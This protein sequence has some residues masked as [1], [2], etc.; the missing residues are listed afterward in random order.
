VLT[1][2][3]PVARLFIVHMGRSLPRSGTPITL[4]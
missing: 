1:D 3:V 2:G 4:P